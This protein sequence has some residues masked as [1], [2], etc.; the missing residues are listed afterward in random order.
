M[1]LGVVFRPC[2]HCAGDMDSLHRVRQ[3]NDWARNDLALEVPYN[4][5]SPLHKGFEHIYNISECFM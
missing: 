1:G 2:S 3:Y 5:L 4:V